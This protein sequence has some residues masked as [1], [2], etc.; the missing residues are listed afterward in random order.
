[1]CHVCA[2]TWDYKDARSVHVGC[3]MMMQHA[4]W[5]EAFGLLITKTWKIHILYL[6]K[7]ILLSVWI[8]RCAHGRMSLSQRALHWLNDI[9]PYAVKCRYDILP[10]AR[11]YVYSICILK[12][13]CSIHPLIQPYQNNIQNHWRSQDFSTGGPSEGPTVGRFFEI[14]CIKM[15]FFAH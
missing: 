7:M 11:R 14:L 8:Y 3:T 9:L 4:V 2:V 5:S 13:K 1:M 15:A 10:C 12:L 6:I